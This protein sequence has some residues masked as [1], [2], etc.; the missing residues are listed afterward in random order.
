MPLFTEEQLRNRARAQVQPQS[1]LFSKNIVKGFINEAISAQKASTHK[2]YD[3]FLSHSTG[4]S[5]QIWGLK[6]ELENLD[7]SVYIDWIDDAQLDRSNV[8]KDTADTLR[9]RMK[10]CKSLFY[11]YSVNAVK[12]KWMPWE[13]GYF[14]GLKEKAAVLPIRA[15]NVGNTDSYSG[16]E[17]LSLYPYI[18]IDNNFQGENTLW[19][20]E[21]QKKFIDYDSW[22]KYNKKPVQHL[23]QR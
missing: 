21:N 17:Y 22:V 10:S 14:D 16:S 20:H 15:S 13:L 19:V 12:S 9:E 4:D 2:N 23:F 3:I 7:Y 8:N 11:A 5:E 6:L 18:S 1:R